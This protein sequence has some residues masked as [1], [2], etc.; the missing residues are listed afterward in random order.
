MNYTPSDGANSLASYWDLGYAEFFPL[1]SKIKLRFY[2]WNSQTDYTAAKELIEFKDYVVSGSNF[3]T[4]FAESVLD[5]AGKTIVTQAWV[6]VLAEDT[7]F[8]TSSPV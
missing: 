7:F 3:T 6:Y 8:A 5:D 2:G 1:S 4:Y